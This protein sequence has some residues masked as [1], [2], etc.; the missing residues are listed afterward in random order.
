MA[1]ALYAK[2]QLILVQC[3]FLETTLLKEL[4]SVIYT[5]KLYLSFILLPV[6]SLYAIL[7]V[8]LLT[9]VSVFISVVH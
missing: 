6:W 1:V 5:Y 4:Y 3:S 8:V 2:T 9:L 7:N